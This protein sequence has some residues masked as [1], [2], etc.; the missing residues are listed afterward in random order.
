MKIPVE[1]ASSIKFIDSYNNWQLL[2]QI[3]TEII[4]MGFSNE[5]MSFTLFKRIPFKSEVPLKQAAFFKDKLF[6]LNQEGAFLANNEPIME[7]CESFLVLSTG[8]FF[9]TK[10]HDVPIL[11]REDQ[12]HS[13]EILPSQRILGVL[14]FTNCLTLL[15][16]ESINF[17]LHDPVQ[18]RFLL[19]DLFAINPDETLL[20]AWEGDPLYQLALE[21]VLLKCLNNKDALECLD[22]LHSSNPRAFSLAIASLTRKVEFHEASQQLF[23]HLPTFT[24]LFVAKNIEL[25]DSLIFLPYLAKSY[26]E[27]VVERKEAITFILKGLFD[28]VRSYRGQIRKIR[29]YL[30]AFADLEELVLSSG[31]RKILSLWS[32][33]RLLKAF[34]L[35]TLLG[36]EGVVSEIPSDKLDYFKVE[37][38]I[39]PELVLP[40]LDWLATRGHPESVINSLKDS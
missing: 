23:A 21:Y 31:K 7:N 39:A 13:I 26:F 34:D 17:S 1:E 5:T 30:S 6:T 37:K 28:G 19:P 18:S 33:G 35:L 29:A 36:I 20:P 4:V 40:F 11:W 10:S 15:L 16:S 38:A 8:H 12:I 25:D 14:P 24:P 22:Q 9:I 2:L 3:P 27:N 32:S